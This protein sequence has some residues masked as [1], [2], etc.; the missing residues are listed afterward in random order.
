ME[1]RDLL[2]RTWLILAV[3]L[4]AV[5]AAAQQCPVNYGQLTKALKASV[6]PSGG[7][8]NGGFDNNEWAVVVSRD[9]TI[10]AV[11]MS[12]SK[13]ADQWLASRAIAAE[14]ANTANAMSLDHFAISTANLYAGSLPGGYLYGASA[15]NPPVPNLIYSG[16]PKTEGTAKDPLVGTHLGGVVSFGGG[17]ALYSAHGVVGGLGVSGDTPCADHNVAWR[18]RHALGLDHIPNGPSPAHN[19]AI[20]YDMLPDKTSASGFGHPGCGGTSEAV[21][22]QIHSGFVP[23]WARVMSK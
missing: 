15:T 12:G 22:E 7:P 20:I 18:V 23:Q 5:P 19:D 3:C 1:V 9:G 10:C 2:L 8:G 6:K 14:K 21:A 11:T 16:D 17:L 13:P 4:F